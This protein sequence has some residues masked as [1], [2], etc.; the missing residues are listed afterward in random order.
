MNYSSIESVDQKVVEWSLNRID[1]VH[2]DLIFVNQIRIAYV[3][4]EV[5]GMPEAC[6][7]PFQFHAVLKI[8]YFCPA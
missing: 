4:T 7:R 1:P 5:V 3:M 2:S 8:P 6:Y